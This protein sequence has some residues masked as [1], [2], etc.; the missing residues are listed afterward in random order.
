MAKARQ[1][2]NDF[3]IQAVILSQEIGGAKAARELGIPVGTLYGWHRA[4]KKGQLDGITRSPEN[5][6]SLSEEVH[7]MLK[8]INGVT[9]KKMIIADNNQNEEDNG[10]DIF[11]KFKILSK[12]QNR[13]AGNLGTKIVIDY[14]KEN[15]KNE[16]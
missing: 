14:V 9:L 2:D 7:F 13:T 16:N 4:W 5:A 3:K 8:N 15:Y 11:E 1:Y 6:M 12:D 10:E